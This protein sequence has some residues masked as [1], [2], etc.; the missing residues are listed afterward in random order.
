VGYR[1]AALAMF[2]TAAIV[3]GAIR[4]IRLKPSTGSALSTS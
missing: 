2:N 4:V 3:G 1:I